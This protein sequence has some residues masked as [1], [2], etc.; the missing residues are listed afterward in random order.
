[1]IRW[2]SGEGEIAPT[3]D[4]KRMKLDNEIHLMVYVITISLP[5]YDFHVAPPLAFITITT[6]LFGYF[7]HE[8][9]NIAKYYMIFI[10]NCARFL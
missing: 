10:P 2:I 3:F 8:Y 5:I 9:V 7:F 1:M 4:M 6:G